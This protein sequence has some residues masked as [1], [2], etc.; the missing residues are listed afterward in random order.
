M[1]HFILLTAILFSPAA[2]ADQPSDPFAKPNYLNAHF[3]IGQAQVFADLVGQT[4]HRSKAGEAR[5][6]LQKLTSRARQLET[7]YK[8][9]GSGEEEAEQKGGRTMAG[10]LPASG[11]WAKGG[12]DIPIEAIRHYQQCASLVGM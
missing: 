4:S 5:L 3:C 2:F 10:L 6:L 1:R 11:T 9:K 8:L 7:R 12:A